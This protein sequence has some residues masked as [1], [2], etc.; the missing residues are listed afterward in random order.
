MQI[1]DD[2]FSR[3]F[4]K[5]QPADRSV[6]P[7]DRPTGL[8]GW[9]LPTAA[10]LGILAAVGAYQLARLSGPGDAPVRVALD[11]RQ[12]PADPDTTGAFLPSGVA[13]AVEMVRL[14]P[15]R[16]PVSDPVRR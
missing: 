11:G 13:Q 12:I 16:R 5:R 3:S 10:V 15:C 9:A 14:D 4:G 6:R 1:R 8:V 7:A 2:R